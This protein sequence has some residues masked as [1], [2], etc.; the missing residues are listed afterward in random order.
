MKA[1]NPAESGSIGVVF[2][3]SPLRTL[4]L[5]DS[6]KEKRKQELGVI[7]MFG[8]ISCFKSSFSHVEVPC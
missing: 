1:R 3:F 7:S 8:Q 2:L 5:P 4:L 6:L